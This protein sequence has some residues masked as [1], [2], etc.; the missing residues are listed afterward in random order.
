[1]R[2]DGLLDAA[3][4]AVL[5]PQLQWLEPPD[6][7]RTEEHEADDRLA[8]VHAVRIPV[9]ISI[10]RIISLFYSSKSL[11]KNI[12][13]LVWNLFC[14]PNSKNTPQE[15]DFSKGKRMEM[16]NEERRKAERAKRNLKREAEQE[17]PQRRDTARLNARAQEEEK[18]GT[19]MEKSERLTEKE[20]NKGGANG[21]RLPFWKERW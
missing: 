6:V 17:T 4:P 21:E 18:Q 14:F 12:T 11:F 3:A 16:Q 2:P 15:H 1:M 10:L 9:R 20:D 19:R 13:R 7:L 8:L 5:G